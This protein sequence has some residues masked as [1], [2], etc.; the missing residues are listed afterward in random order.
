MSPLFAQKPLE[1]KHILQ[2]GPQG[3]RRHGRPDSGELAGARGR[4]KALKWPLLPQGSILWLSWGGKGAD[5]G[6]R[7]RATVVGA[8]AGR[9]ARSGV[10]WANTCVVELECE[11]LACERRERREGLAVCGANGG[12]GAAR[13]RRE[14]MGNPFITDE[15]RVGLHIYIAMQRTERQGDPDAC[16]VGAQDGGRHGGGRRARD[17]LHAA[18]TSSQDAQAVCGLGERGTSGRAGRWGLG[19]RGRERMVDGRAN[20]RRRAMSR[21][22]ATH[23]RFHSVYPSLT[24]NNSKNLNWTA[25]KCE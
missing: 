4:A 14:A 8:A 11:V 25:L 16:G 3:G 9:P 12:G 15:R 2:C 1:W 7:R 21:R 17:E 6:A 10:E 22:G 20:A 18:G 24:V 19:R 5:E 23:P 13:L